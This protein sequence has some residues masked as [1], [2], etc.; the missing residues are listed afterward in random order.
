MNLRSKIAQAAVA[1]LL[2][3]LCP[4]RGTTILRIG[5]LQGEFATRQVCESRYAPKVTGPR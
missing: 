2:V 1:L 4:V 3:R 5:T